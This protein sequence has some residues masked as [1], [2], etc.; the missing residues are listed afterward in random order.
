[1]MTRL[2]TCGWLVLFAAGASTACGDDTSTPAPETDATVSD[3]ASS[4]HCVCTTPAPCET[5]VGAVCDDTGA[6]IYPTA[7][8]G[9]SCDDGDACTLDDTCAAGA[10]VPG[11]ALPCDDGDTCNGTETCAS[12]SGC[13]ATSAS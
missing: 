2:L 11:P 5:A 9:A 6:C 13:F 1:M 12:A 10:C 4:D 3:D 7:E 8:D